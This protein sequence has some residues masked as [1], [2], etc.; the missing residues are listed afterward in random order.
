MA[1]NPQLTFKFPAVDPSANLTASPDDLNGHALF[2]R[3]DAAI[4]ER[5]SSMASSSNGHVGAGRGVRSFSNPG[6]NPMQVLDSFRDN[7]RRKRSLS[8]SAVEVAEALKAPV[9]P[10]LIVRIYGRFILMR[11]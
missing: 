10:R 8:V 3:E 7:A 9:S 11:D 6:G 2:D 4:R 1:Q 5:G